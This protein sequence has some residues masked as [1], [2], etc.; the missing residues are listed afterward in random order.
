MRDGHDCVVY[1]VSKGAVSELV[2]EGS[3]GSGSLE[4]FVGLLEKPR[5]VW[6]MVPAGYVQETVDQLADLLDADDV[7]FGVE[8][9]GRRQLDE[10]ADPPLPLPREAVA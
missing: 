8:G 5:A 10:H 1:D 3:A 7:P 2:S 4:E 9:S 6:M